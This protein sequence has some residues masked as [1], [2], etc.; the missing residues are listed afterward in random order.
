MKHKD[1]YFL[2]LKDETSHPPEKNIQVT[3]SYFLMTEGYGKAFY[4]H[5]RQITGLK[6]PQDHRFDNRWWVYSNNRMLIHA[7]G[8][9]PIRRFNS[10]NIYL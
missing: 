6:D 8:H 4:P 3:T 10:L 2:F 7:S 1:K 9:C 5:H